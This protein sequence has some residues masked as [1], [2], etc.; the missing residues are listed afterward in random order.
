MHMLYCVLVTIFHNSIAFILFYHGYSFS[1]VAMSAL[2]MANL[3]YSP[4]SCERMTVVWG[5]IE[6]VATLPHQLKKLLMHL[7]GV[8]VLPA[9]FP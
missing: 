4:L 2:S 5:G 7:H 1:L 3:S 8:L 9:L 6:E